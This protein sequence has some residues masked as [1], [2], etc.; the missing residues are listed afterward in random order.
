MLKRKHNSWRT[1]VILALLTAALPACGAS[2]ETP[3]PTPAGPQPL[4]A[5]DFSNT[6]SGWLESA[7]GQ[8]SQ[9]YRDGRFF[10][11]VR[12]PDLIVWDNPGLN[13]KDF[14]LQVTAR[15]VSGGPENSYG[16]LLRYIDEGNFYR[17]DL[18]E[19]GGYAVLKSE[20]HEWVTL[21]DWRES[22]HV[23]PLGEANRI[24]VACQGDEMVFYV[25]DQFLVSVQDDSF[26][27][28]DVGL[29]A[30]TFAE[31]NVE[32]E[33]DDLEVWDIKYK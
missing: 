22:A 18:T 13:L 17:F 28:G 26:E 32:V 4:F 6:A 11:E 29:F 24:Q 8:A 14:D 10:F 9:G 1:F 12:V 7:D 19:D 16:V 20:H 25:N 3:T 21:A 31:P 33:F 5:D 15:Q 2:A 30:S 23:K 27:R